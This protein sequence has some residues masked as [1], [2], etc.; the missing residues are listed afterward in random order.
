MHV[1]RIVIRNLTNMAV[2]SHMS[3]QDYHHH[4]AILPSQRTH[5]AVEHTALTT[6][7][8]MPHYTRHSDDV[9]AQQPAAWHE[10]L[11]TNF[12]ES[13]QVLPTKHRLLASV[14]FG[15]AGAVLL[16]MAIVRYVPTVSQRCCWR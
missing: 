4:F 14:I 16:V 15:V 11:G 8:A 10:D 1:M 3:W 13:C 5:R 12:H 6:T 9:E 2:E 7:A